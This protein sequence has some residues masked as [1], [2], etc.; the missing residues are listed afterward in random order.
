MSISINPST[1]L[2]VFA[3]R[4]AKATDK[5]AGKGYSPVADEALTS[6]PEPPP[7]A[8]FN[9]AEQARYRD[10][11]EARRGAADYMAM[12][13]EFSR[14]L[15]DVYS[16]DPVEREALT[17]ECE[18]LVVGAGFAGLLLWYK[19]QKAGFQDVRFCE[20]GGDVGGTWYWNRYPGIACDVEAY[21]YLP[22]LEEMGSIPSMKFASG[23]E[24]MEY[25]QAMAEKDSF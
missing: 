2:K 23:F 4:A 11:K 8:V 7:G 6:L 18:I 1:G 5:I 19:L 24:I 3:T 14:Y 12:E 21:S 16:A 20:K 13:G 15:E 17:D 22:L 25:C 10:F 9:A